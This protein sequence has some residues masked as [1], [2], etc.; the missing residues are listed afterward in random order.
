MAQN[1][2]AAGQ[3]G[4]LWTYTIIFWVGSLLAGRQRNLQLTAHTLQLVTLLLVPVNFWAMDSFGLVLPPSVGMLVVGTAALTLTAITIIHPTMRNDPSRLASRGF[5]LLWLS[6]LHWGWQWPGLALIAVYL[7][8]IATAILLPRYSSALVQKP[9]FL[10]KN[11]DISG[12]SSPETRF[13]IIDNRTGSSLVIYALAVLLGRGIFVQGEPIT[14]LGLAIGICGWLLARLGQPPE[15]PPESS[16]SFQSKVWE[17]VGG[18]LLL[19]GWLVAVREPFPWQATVVSGLGLWFFGNRWQRF[20]LRRDLLGMFLV[21]LQVHWLLWRLLPLELQ[22]GVVAFFTQVTNS[23]DYPFGLL[24]LA[25]FPYVIGMV[26]LT[27]RIYAPH[28]TKLARFS[29]GLT[30]W[31]GLV[32]TLISLANPTLRSLNLLLSTI[33]LATVI[34]YWKK[35]GFL[36]ENADTSLSFSP[37]TR[38]V[39]MVYLTHITGLLTLASVID[40]RLP[41][42]TQPVWAGILLGVMVVEWGFTVRG[43]RKSRTSVQKPGFLGKNADTF[44]V[45]LTRNPVSQQKI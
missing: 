45:I 31:F 20:W 28:Q 5:L 36:G 7:G 41:N 30:F 4:V 21:G 33:T 24:S 12:S 8:T 27:Q 44:W 6:Y 3:Y 18:M 2:P 14:Q 17:A 43:R 40:W 10:G 22:Q 15:S 37:E 42:L 9:G 29:E 13:L 26:V 25:L 35:P 16:P 34:H 1:F 11:A 19:I 38:L 39:R 23:V 32:L